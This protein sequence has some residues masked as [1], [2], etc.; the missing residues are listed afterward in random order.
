MAELN[1]EKPNVKKLYNTATQFLKDN[2]PN[3]DN[4]LNA[5]NFYASPSKLFREKI[6]THLWFRRNMADLK[7]SIASRN[8]I[9]ELMKSMRTLGGK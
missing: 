4:K 2:K 9:N 8:Q 3:S 1:K 7:E 6:I 5:N